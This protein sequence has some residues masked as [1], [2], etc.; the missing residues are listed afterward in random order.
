MDKQEF[1]NRF[2]ELVEHGG[3]S[4]YL[5]MKY[6]EELKDYQRRSSM[7]SFCFNLTTSVEP[8]Q[9]NLFT[10]DEYIKIDFTKELSLEIAKILWEELS[11]IT[12][13]DDEEIEQT[14]LH[15]D[16]GTVNTEIWH[17]FEWY[18]DLSIGNDILN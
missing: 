3:V 8:N 9:F 4:N 14:F 7:N 17:W 18:F 13:N 10:R 12:I 11:N 5:P 15:F 6:N 16:I 2:K 1:I